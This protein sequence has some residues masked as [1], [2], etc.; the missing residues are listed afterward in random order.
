M[1]DALEFRAARDFL[2]AHRERYDEAYA[3]FRWPRLARFNWALDHFDAM[4]RG[5]D[6][7]ALWIVR[8]GS[9]VRL[10]FAELAARSDRVANALEPLARANVLV[11]ALAS[12]SRTVE[13]PRQAA[14]CALRR[15]PN[16]ALAS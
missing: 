10:S 7:T 13:R 12:N 4:A 3:G 9:D 15:K 1:S 6:R 11:P 14:P 8:D 16:M 2:L 5:N